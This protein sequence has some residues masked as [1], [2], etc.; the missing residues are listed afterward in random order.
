MFLL[1]FAFTREREREKGKIFWVNEPTLKINR[2][3]HISLQIKKARKRV[4]SI[5]T[6]YIFYIRMDGGVRAR[7]V[8]LLC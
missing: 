1:M 2:L 4:F 8:L 5:S 3:R 6:I 7:M